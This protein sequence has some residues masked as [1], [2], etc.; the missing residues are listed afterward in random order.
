MNLLP[1][2]FCFV[3]NMYRLSHHLD[4]HVRGLRVC[5]ACSHHLHGDDVDTPVLTP[6]PLTPPRTPDP[7]DFVPVTPPRTPAAAAAAA[8]GKG[9]GKGKGIGK[10]RGQGR[11]KGKGQG[12]GKGGC[13]GIGKGKSKG[14]GKG[15][16]GLAET[17]V[18]VTEYFGSPMSDSD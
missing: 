15:Q 1:H 16:W 4:V 17:R 18:G 6:V 3:C 8:A 13:K 7:G 5:V 12:R 2:E 14:K 9:G 10:G 11:G